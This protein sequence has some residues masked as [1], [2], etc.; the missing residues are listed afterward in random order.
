MVGIDFEYCSPLPDKCTKYSGSSKLLS[1]TLFPAISLSSK[2]LYPHYAF[3]I[4]LFNFALSTCCRHIVLLSVQLCLV[5][6]LQTYR[7][8]LS[9][10]LP[11]GHAADISCCSCFNF[12]LLTCCR[13][14]AALSSTL[15]CLHAADISCCS[16]FNFALSTCCRHIVLL[17]VQL[18]LV[19][20]LQTYHAALSSTFPSMSTRES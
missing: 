3:N 6:M 11:C 15:P 2:I 19:D 1:N 4:Q 13:H 8:A 16:Q 18:C 5:D 14:C 17:S 12:A 7:A 9:S 10:T 20:M